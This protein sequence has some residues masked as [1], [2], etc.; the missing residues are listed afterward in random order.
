M[1]SKK[2]P[3]EKF[4]KL[5]SEERLTEMPPEKFIETLEFKEEM[6]IA[7]IG[8]GV[9]VHAIL[10][11]QKLSKLD[12]AVL[13]IDV[14]EFM[15]EE[16]RRAAEETGLTNIQYHL[17]ET[18]DLKLEPNSIDLAYLIAVFHEFPDPE[19]ALHQIWTALKPNGWIY[20]VDM[21]LKA[22]PEERGPPDEHRIPLPK[23]LAYVMK[24]SPFVKATNEFYPNKYLIQVQKKER[25]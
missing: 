21:N 1:M 8:V 23:A 24:L 22:H 13:A 10:A 16:T 2:F 15:L 4:E 6:V 18:V 20:I 9:G 5:R 11:A 25:V 17:A 14:E 3:T 7:D 19:K 12:G